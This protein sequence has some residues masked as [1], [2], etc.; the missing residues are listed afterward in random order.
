MAI[1]LVSAI[2]CF[3]FCGSPETAQPVATVILFL[4]EM[5]YLWTTQTSLLSATH[6]Q[7][8]R[9]TRYVWMDMSQPSN[10]AYARIDAMRRVHAEGNSR[11]IVF[12]VFPMIQLIDI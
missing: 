5:I 11:V 8:P 7:A 9:L 10:R 1:F 2:M 12:L 6:M 4:L 3:R